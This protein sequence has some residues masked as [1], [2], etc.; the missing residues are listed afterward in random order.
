MRG[1][2][3]R[4]CYAVLKKDSQTRFWE[5]RD[6]LEKSLPDYMIPTGI[7][8]LDALP[9]NSNGK[10]DR[11]ALPKPK[12]IRRLLKHPY[13]APSGE[14]QCC[15]ASI[16][17]EVLGLDDAGVDDNFFDVGGHS[18]TAFMIL[19]RIEK[20]FP[21]GMSVSSVFGNPTIR[22]F[23]E[24]LQEQTQCPSGVHRP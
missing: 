10:V 5:F 23:S 21:N 7:E 1:H 18:L 17:E 8:V 12:T 13:V 16:W 24:L 11:A 15:L 14:V 3:Q 22:L 4:N 20:T 6:F 9:V 2:K 19:T